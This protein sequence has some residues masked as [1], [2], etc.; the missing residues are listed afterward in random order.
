MSTFSNDDLASE[1]QVVARQ[2]TFVSIVLNVILATLQVVVGVIAHS[3][4]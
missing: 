3:R 1:K 4:L 2:S